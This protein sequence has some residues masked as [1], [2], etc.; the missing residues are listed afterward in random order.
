MRQKKIK[1]G[2]F[3]TELFGN[4]NV[5]I[6][7]ETVYVHCA[8]LS[9][10]SISVQITVSCLFCLKLFDILYCKIFS[11]MCIS[12]FSDK[13]NLSFLFLCVLLVVDVLF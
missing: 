11:M 3:L 10:N 8:L 7:W 4:K 9:S 12:Y 5:I 13:Y 6:F 1:I 2:S